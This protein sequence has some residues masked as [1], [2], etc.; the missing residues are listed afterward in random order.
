MWTAVGTCYQQASIAQT[1]QA[2]QAYQR[3][4]ELGDPDGVALDRL[5]RL[6]EETGQMGEGAMRLRTWLQGMPGWA[7]L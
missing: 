4:V 3:A 6:Y 2:I 1:G 5:A 7:L